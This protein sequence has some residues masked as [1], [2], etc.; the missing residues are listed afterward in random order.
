MYADNVV[1]L[2]RPGH[3]LD[4]YVQAS[5]AI[6]A[7]GFR[8]KPSSVEL[9]GTPDLTL[10]LP[11]VGTCAAKTLNAQPS[12]RFLGQLLAFSRSWRES[13]DDAFLAA[14]ACV[15]RELQMA[16]HATLASPPSPRNS[17]LRLSIRPACSPL[18]CSTDM[19]GHSQAASLGGPLSPVDPRHWARGRTLYA[20]ALSL[21][22]PSPAH[23][24]PAWAL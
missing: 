11:A 19:R 23:R 2:A 18:P 5:A 4:M 8:W 20:S 21:S 16:S 1:L 12:V 17:T 3:F 13:T 9:L 22:S 7:I 15:K 10:D 24:R 6:S 14:N